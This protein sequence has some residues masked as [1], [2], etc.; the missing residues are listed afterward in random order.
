MSIWRYDEAAPL[1]PFY[2][3]NQ[4]GCPFCSSA[5]KELGKV[6][7]RE[8][9]FDID[10]GVDARVCPSCGWWKLTQSIQSI[11][12]DDDPYTPRSYSHRTYAAVGSLTDLDLTDLSW[13]IHEIKSY[14]TARFESRFNIHPRLFEKTVESVMKDLGY[15][16]RVISYSNDGG[17]DVIL[18]G[19]DGTTIGVQVKRYRQS[20][21]V[22]QIRSLIGA[23][24]L[25]GHT[26]GVFIT[27]SHFQ[28][29]AYKAAELSAQK[30][31]PVTLVNGAQF[32]DA[33]KIA[34]MSCYSDYDLSSVPFKDVPLNVLSYNGG[35]CS[36]DERYIWEEPPDNSFN[37]TR[38]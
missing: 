15:K 2:F 21:E 19:S 29:G 34:Q 14:L 10:F 26:E 35:A 3:N 8:S 20:I 4:S 36:Q 37:P 23:L 32:F 7:D 25:G 22:E 28:A 17:V 33:L 12:D 5:M 27:T 11:F 9:I 31:L 1:H 18:D 6:S 13:P 38:R 30:G 16:A 24:M